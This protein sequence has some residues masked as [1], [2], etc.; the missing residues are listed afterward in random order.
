MTLIRI[1]VL[2][3]AL[4]LG[5]GQAFACSCARADSA[6]QQ[7]AGYELIFVGTPT[8]ITTIAPAPPKRS[9]WQRLQ[10]WKPA[11]EPVDLRWQPVELSTDFSIE[12]VLKG[13]QSASVTIRTTEPD[14]AN[15]GTSFQEQEVYLILAYRS[16]DGIYRTNSCSWPQFSR[17]EFEAAL[18]VSS[19]P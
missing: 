11:P 15:C 17:A 8:A 6:E 14:G 13:P 18:G 9:F 4:A 10:F 12:S 2:V 16:D 1:I 19:A 5:A 7:A 3:T